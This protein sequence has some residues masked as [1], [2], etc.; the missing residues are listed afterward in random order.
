MYGL[1]EVH[2]VRDTEDIYLQWT[3][4]MHYL[5][6]IQRSYEVPGAEKFD[7]RFDYYFL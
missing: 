2:K 7:I 5:D 3:V 6:S 4:S 1:T